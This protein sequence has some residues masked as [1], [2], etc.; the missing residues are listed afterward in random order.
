MDFSD[1]SRS[2]ASPVLV[3][4]I[5]RSYVAA[6]DPPVDTAEQRQVDLE[7]IK[8]EEEHQRFIRQKSALLTRRNASAPICRLP[9]EC[10]S[11]IFLLAF[12]EET[13]RRTGISYNMRRTRQGRSPS[14]DIPTLLSHV[15]ARFRAI[16][17]SSPRL[18]STFVLQP[19]RPREKHSRYIEDILERI[20]RS[21]ATPVEIELR[22]YT[23]SRPSEAPE[24]AALKVELDILSNLLPKCRRLKVD[25]PWR[26]DA[27]NLVCR[28]MISEMP[29]VEDLVICSDEDAPSRIVP[30]PL[31]TNV[32]YSLEIHHAELQSVTRSHFKELRSLKLISS[33]VSLAATEPDLAR[34]PALRD[35]WRPQLTQSWRNC[36]PMQVLQ[37]ATKLKHLI[38][39]DVTTTNVDAET[40]TVTFSELESLELALETADGS[41]D[42]T[43]D[44]DLAHP[45]IS[46]I[47]DVLNHINMPSLHCLSLR[48]L[49]Y[50]GMQCGT[51]FDILERS[52]MPLQELSLKSV[53]YSAHE[54]LALLTHFPLLTTLTLEYAC[55]T[56]EFLEGMR[57]QHSRPGTHCPALK[58]LTI[59]HTLSSPFEINDYHQY[60]MTALRSMVRSRSISVVVPAISKLVVEDTHLR[61]LRETRGQFKEYVEH[62]ELNEKRPRPVRS[63]LVYDGFDSLSEDEFGILS[64]LS[65]D[66]WD[67]IW[68]PDD[69]EVLADFGAFDDGLPSHWEEYDPLSE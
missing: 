33:G 45:S 64:P 41:Q 26:D 4:I 49:E 8:L 54:F 17:L 23:A 1:Y 51:I 20:A 36:M 37:M 5:P 61:I 65:A 60:T 62:L 28:Y 53:H 55:V 40:P 57:A 12:E 46:S 30:A 13:S 34:I 9:D 47:T 39:R 43:D 69:D 67:P 58:E 6:I 59:K 7:L 2:T 32:L 19:G 22:A 25:L 18:W 21:K 31:G 66:G 24:A 50:E 38:M 48:G 42:L 14:Q 44:L 29:L 15:S 3:P 63:S 56:K 52:D 11:M 35:S 16:V 10:L 68:D 27:R